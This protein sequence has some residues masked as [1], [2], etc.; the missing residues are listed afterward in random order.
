VALRTRANGSAGSASL[1]T[2]RH[3]LPSPAA[4]R[5]LAVSASGPPACNAIQAEG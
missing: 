1:S 4:E 3:G 5:T 2:I